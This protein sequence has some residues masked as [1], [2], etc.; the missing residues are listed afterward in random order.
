MR[1][2]LQIAAGVDVLPLMAAIHQKP[3]LWDQNTLR[4]S[5]T[6]TPHK[7]VSDIWLWFNE[8][9]SD[10]AEAIDDIQTIP[11]P[12]WTEL[13]QVRPIVFDLMRR[14]ESVQLGRCLITRLSP[15][16]CIDAHI[17]QGTP[18]T[19]YTRFCIALQ[20]GP[21]S[22][23][24]IEDEQ[25]C[26]KPGDVWMINNRAEHSVSNLSAMD[27]VVLIADLRMG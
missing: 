11:Y 18:A 10:P 21:G 26:M 3:H 6:L 7:D 2:F 23:F 15:G 8:L 27:R 13:P 20:N 19:Y 4:T 1:H 5:H 17:D 14:M 9:K 24:K 25:V 12:A 16:K 22:L